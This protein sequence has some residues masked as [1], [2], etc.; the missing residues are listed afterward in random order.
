MANTINYKVITS[1]TVIRNRPNQNAK[2]LGYL[3][4][5]NTIDVISISNEWAYFKYNKKNAYIKI[6]DIQPVQQVY[7]TG[8]L[9]IEYID[10]DSNLEIQPS[11]TYTNREL[12]SYT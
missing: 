11:S 6:S 8:N 3:Y 4:Q 12:K 1:S 7:I 2:I 9:T 10:I 5:N